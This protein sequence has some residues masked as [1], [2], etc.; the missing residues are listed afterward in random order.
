[1]KT[2]IDPGLF[3]KMPT[4]VR[5]AVVVQFDNAPTQG[6]MD[7]LA[8]NLA[9]CADEI[10]A[11]DDGDD[12]SLVWCDFFRSVGLNP[13]KYPPAHLNLRRRI[14]K[15][16]TPPPICPVVAAF[17]LVSLTLNTP[18]GGDDLRQVMGLADTIELGFADGTETFEGLGS[19]DLGAVKAGELTYKAD[20]TIVSRF[21]YVQ[22]SR[23]TALSSSTLDALVNIDA[24]GDSAEEICGSGIDLL[25]QIVTAMGGRTTTRILSSAEPEGVFAC[26]SR[27]E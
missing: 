5:A 27:E 4:L 18:A 9:E 14:K 16:W 8:Q 1:M 15:G 11:S 26:V 20:N 12:G 21:G 19:G 10:R 3:I 24:C 23:L 17:N 2:R 7:R 25:N 6:H 13:N 22:N